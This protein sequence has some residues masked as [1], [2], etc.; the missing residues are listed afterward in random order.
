MG[1]VLAGPVTDS[2][3]LSPPCYWLGGGGG[4]KARENKKNRALEADN[5][6]AVYTN[7][8]LWYGG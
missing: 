8:C 5:T 1:A 7:T 3:N 6:Q 2:V 4:V